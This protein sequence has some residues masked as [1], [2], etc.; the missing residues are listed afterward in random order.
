MRCALVHP[1][2]TGMSSTCSRSCAALL[3]LGVLCFPAATA[4]SPGSCTSG[5]VGGICRGEGWHGRRQAGRC[6]G[7]EAKPSEPVLAAAAA[8]AAHVGQGG[9][10]QALVE[11]PL[12][13]RQRDVVGLCDRPGQQEGRRQ[14]AEG[15]P[16]SSCCQREACGHPQRHCRHRSP[17]PHQTKRDP[18]ARGTLR[19]GPSST[20]RQGRR[21]DD[22]RPGRAPTASARSACS[23]RLRERCGLAAPAPPRP[24]PLPSRCPPAP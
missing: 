1:V 9:G 5:S 4:G 14:S 16:A 20:A 11:L 23:G 21:R 19:S 17:L 24:L 6:A 22:P 15:E 13:A 7:L 2:H 12:Q 3:A 8:A 18:P 10:N